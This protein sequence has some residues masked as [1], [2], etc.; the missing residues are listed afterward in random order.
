M[1]AKPFLGQLGAGHVQGV[2]SMCKNK[3]TISS[4]ASGSGDGVIKVWDLTA[5]DEAWRTAGHSNIVKGLTFTND[6]KLLS[7]GTDGI[8]LWDPYNSPSDSLPI[9][10][11]QEG[12]PYTALTC[13]RSGNS[14]AASSGAGCISVWDLDTSSAPQKIQWPNFADT[15]TDICFN[16]VETSIIGSTATDRS[17]ILFDLRTNMPVLKTILKFAANRIV[18]NPM[19]AMNMAVASEDHNMYLFDARNFTKAQNVMKGHVAAVMDVEFSPT[20]EELVSGSY[21]SF[22]FTPSRPLQHANSNHRIVL[23]GYGSATRASLVIFTTQ[24][25][26]RGTL[27]RLL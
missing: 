11:W 2:Y 5:R 18:F 9:S 26:C 3:S 17:V 7:C 21:V 16:Q 8:K 25:E 6:N 22:L 4:V 12:G 19:E 10:T 27:R 1:F 23:S 15:I 20:G 14:F 13:H 24:S